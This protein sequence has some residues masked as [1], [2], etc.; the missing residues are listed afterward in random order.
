MIWY[1]DLPV[2]YHNLRER[3]LLFTESFRQRVPSSK[4]KKCLRKIYGRHNEL[5]ER[6][7]ISVSQTKTMDMFLF[8]CPQYRPPSSRMWYQI[9]FI[10]R[11]AL[12][13]ETQRGPSVEKILLTLRENLISPPVFGGLVWLHF[14]FLTLC[15]CWILLFV[16]LCC[17]LLLSFVSLF[18][19]KSKQD[20]EKQM[21]INEKID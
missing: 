7:E 12:T 19:I 4:V 11:W 9:R 15:L 17:F 10:Y 13:W 3:E 6:Y 16:F 20:Q 8:L 14:C 1:S 2:S 21:Y 18:F 5:V